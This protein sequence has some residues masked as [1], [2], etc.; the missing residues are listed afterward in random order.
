M[1]LQHPNL[2]PNQIPAIQAI[3]LSKTYARSPKPAVEPMCLEVYQGEIFGFLGPNGAGKTTTI[4][5][6]LD[7]IKPTSGQARILGYDCQKS[8]VKSREQIGYIPG[9]LRL[10]PNY[11]GTKIVDL[12]MSTKPEPVSNQ[13]INYLCKKLDVEMDTPTARLSLGNRQKIGLLLALMAKPSLLILDEPTLG[14]DP[15]IQNQVLELLREVKDEGR[16]VFLSSHVLSEVEQIC[17]RIGIIRDGHLVAVEEIE[18]MQKRLLKYLH[19][20]FSESVDPKVFDALPNTTVTESTDK[21]L[22]IA[23]SG[24]INQVI[25]LISQY[26]VESLESGQPS[27][28]NVFM[29][30]YQDNGKEFV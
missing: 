30:Y 25:K 12:L 3:G 15:I 22:S 1:T 27:L 19:V 7:L 26:K 10:Y 14:L 23:I 18:S 16:T 8:S 9:E 20:T 6:L 28:E 11:S 24:D 5:M 13:Y 21:T 29:G 2:S 4:K 17:D